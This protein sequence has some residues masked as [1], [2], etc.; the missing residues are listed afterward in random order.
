M[1]TLEEQLH[2]Q[3][4]D[5]LDEQIQNR[6]RLNSIKSRVQDAIDAIEINAPEIALARLKSVL[7]LIAEQKLN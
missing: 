6:I 4:H 7:R 2:I 1:M 3:A 5:L